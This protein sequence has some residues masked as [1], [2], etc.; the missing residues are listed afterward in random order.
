MSGLLDGAIVFDIY[1]D[2]EKRLLITV[3]HGLLIVE[4]DGA[5][6]YVEGIGA[7]PGR[8][9]TATVTSL[10]PGPGGT[11][12]A[13]T[14]GTGLVLF[15]PA[16][17]RMLRLRYD[18]ARFRSLSHDT[19]IDL[20]TDRQG[21]LW[22]ATWGGG[23][24]RITTSA[25][26]LAAASPPPP[27]PAVVTDFDVTSLYGDRSGKLWIGTRSGGLLRFDPARN[28]ND[29][30]LETRGR[31]VL[32]FSED[33]DGVV[34]AGTS[35]ELIRI[36]PETGSV[37]IHEHDSSDPKSPGPGYVRALLHD[38][39]GRFWIGT[40][41]G[42][43]Q[44]VDTAARV[45]R[46]FRHDREDQETLSDDYV[47]ALL[48]DRGGTLWIGTRSGGLNAL[49]PE[50]GR[51]QRFIPGPP[52]S[53]QLSHH[54]V[55]SL[56]EGKDGSL[57]VGTGGGLNRLQRHDDGSFNISSFSEAE[58][59]IDDNVMALVLDDD[60]SLWAS[61]KL[62][63]SRHDPSTGTFINYY[64]EDGLPSTE[65]EPG[66]SA[67]LD[68]GLYF[69]TVRW[70]AAAPAGTP[71]PRIPPSR[72]V[73]RDI[74]LP[75]RG[76][77][78]GEPAWRVDRLAIPYGQWFSLDLATLDRVGGPSPDY[79]YR[80]GGGETDWIELG[81]QRSVT[82]TDLRPG[83]YLFEARGHDNQSA[84]SFI[85][86]PITITIVPPFWMT[87]WFRGLILILVVAG[88]LS[89]HFGRMAAVNRR[90]REL[91]QLQQQREQAEDERETAIRRL[92]AV[93][94]SLERAKEDER[95][96]VAR[97]LH[98]DLGPALTAVLINLQL[99]G[100]EPLSDQASGRISETT[101]LVD[102]LVERIRDLSLNLRPPLLDD[103]GLIV[104]LK[105]YMETQ[106]ERTGQR[107][108]VHEQNV[109]ERLGPEVEIT[110]FRIAQEAV[111]NAIR[112]ASADTVTVTV[113]CSKGFL[114]LRI[115]DDGKGFDVSDVLQ[116]NADRQGPRA[117]RHAGK[118]AHAGWRLRHRFSAR[119]GN[120]R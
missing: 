1:E 89:V 98:D 3:D 75:G 68:R 81:T 94:R 73:V 59:L 25:M 42:G 47:T 78:E 13:G 87:T 38:R 93:A 44:Q 6:S 56:V 19:V 15:D 74:R 43:L 95:K 58:G 99:V 106:M 34:W 16:S 102:R 79:S 65:F 41:E 18:P 53:G 51:V 52:G 105:G 109:P 24:S 36:D 20:M 67:R 39:T 97:E 29:L 17:R 14:H 92:R 85:E 32:A 10:A 101:D 120:P 27:P 45:V 71:L 22:I 110:G 70:V 80:V 103:L 54:L 76:L 40:G 114:D 96:H 63:L 112:H 31:T 4:P 11:V 77:R 12:W 66:A 9:G 30:F 84:W 115:E 62:G 83:R 104:S 72:V 8:P 119:P 57:W 60:G 46:S 26:L 55:T 28:R 117:A 108:L 86:P 118:G 107:I 64:K 48:E 33:A 35:N 91:E 23:V 116:K 90:N 82:F 88:A 21:T 37:N 7:A 100:R 5:A 113:T 50:D 111:T 69:G 2:D 49:D 61:S